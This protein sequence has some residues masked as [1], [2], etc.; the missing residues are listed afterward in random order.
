LLGRLPQYPTQFSEERLAI[1]RVLNEKVS[2]TARGVQSQKHF[3][4]IVAEE[5]F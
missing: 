1:L 2:A 4:F 5:E 3:R